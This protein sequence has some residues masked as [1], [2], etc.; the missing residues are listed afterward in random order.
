[1]K[2]DAVKVMLIVFAIMILIL[3]I[4]AITAATNVRRS[5]ATSDWVN[6]THAV[7][8]ETRAVVSCLNAGEASLRSYLLTQDKA[9]QGAYRGHFNA[10]VEH[11]EVVKALTRQEPETHKGVLSLEAL[12]SRRVDLA[13]DLVRAMEQ[14]GAEAARNAL[15]ADAGSTVPAEI[16]FVVNKLATWQNELLRERDKA[17]YLQAQATRWTIWVGLAINF[18]LLVFVGWLISDDIAARRRATS[19]LEAANAMLEE[20]VRER[21][22]EL[23]KANEE[24]RKENLERQ[25]SAQVLEHQLRYSDLIINSLNEHVLVISKAMNVSR[26]NP[27]V[28]HTTGYELHEIV[29]GPLSKIMRI[30]DPVEDS[31]LRFHQALKEGRELQDQPGFLVHKS[32]RGIPVRFSMAPLG[33]SNKVVGSVL[34]VRP[35]PEAPRQPA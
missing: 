18:M 10:M 24:L 7:I 5:I 4:T 13:R 29:G 6:H 25:W 12:V 11:L 32:G 26:V 9:H 27:V 3:G 20:K 23:V 34:T 22:A 15:R 1:M 17:S 33:D 28:G 30:P 16:D 8:L 19:A 2:T 35:G 14:G 31:A 21:T